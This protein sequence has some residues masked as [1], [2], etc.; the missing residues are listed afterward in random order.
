MGHGDT[1]MFKAVLASLLVASA[2]AAGG[3]NISSL[4]V[5]APKGHTAKVQLGGGNAS[6]YKIGITSEAEFAIIQV[7]G[8]PTVSK[9]SFSC[10]REECAQRGRAKGGLS[11]TAASSS[12]ILA[13]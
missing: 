11:R 13:R 8:R 10:Y 5:N 4:S 3:L 9:V 1:T 2:S 12:S 7:S 6:S